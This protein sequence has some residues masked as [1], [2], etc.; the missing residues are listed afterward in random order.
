M[1][2]I[3]RSSIKLSKD[4]S[5]DNWLEELNPEQIN[6]SFDQIGGYQD[7]KDTLVSYVGLLDKIDK[8]KKWKVRVLGKI[9]LHGP[10]GTGKTTI[11]KALAKETGKP[12]VILKTTNIMSKYISETGKNLE[13]AFQLI[14]SKHDSIF[15]IDEFDSIAKTRESTGDHDEMRRVVNVLLTSFDNLNLVEH[16]ILTVA[17]TN[18]EIILDDAVWRRFDAILYFNLPNATQRGQIVKILTQNIPTNALQLNPTSLKLI[19]ATENWSGADLQRLITRA[20]IDLLNG[21]FNKITEDLLLS[22][23]EEKKITPTSM[24][25][26]KPFHSIQRESIEKKQTYKSKFKEFLESKNNRIEGKD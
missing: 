11:V 24:R 23:I 6:E 14:K 1:W 10:P 12:L 9:L 20:V 26:Y 2:L 17:A 15:F 4:F 16:H 22:I 19:N 5:S 3:I 21:K 25:A 18:F 8:L 7:I 13:K